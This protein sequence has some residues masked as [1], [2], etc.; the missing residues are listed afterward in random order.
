M[1]RK[2]MIFLYLSAVA[3]IVSGQ[4]ISSNV[5]NFCF[6]P[7]EV[8]ICRAHFP[9]FYFNTKTKSCDCFIYGGCLGND[10]RFP[11]LQECMQACH[12]RP[13]L[14]K[15]SAKCDKVLG[16][17]NPLANEQILN[18]IRQMSPLPPHHKSPFLAPPEQA[19]V[20]QDDPQQTPPQQSP[21]QQTG[22]F[23]DDPQQTPPQQPPPQQTPLTQD[24]PQQTPLIQH[25]PPQQIPPFQQPPPPQQSQ[26]YQP[27]QQSQLYQ[28]PQQTTRPQQIPQF[29]HRPQQIP[30]FQHRPQ[31]IHVC[32]QPQLTH[33]PVTQPQQ[34]QYYQR[35]QQTQHYQRPLGQL[36]PPALQT[37]THTNTDEDIVVSQIFQAMGITQGT[38]Y[39]GQPAYPIP[40]WMPINADN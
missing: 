25:D 1:A 10:N 15:N 5:P 29:Q 39:I 4:E 34:T 3:V 33:R 22:L 28:P 18:A 20:F 32:P 7:P 13:S 9:S 31:Q 27:P 12:V 21:P 35:P 37:W 14:Q 26:L 6:D 11:T 36:I 23:Q 17:D 8:G 24:D 38:L 19:P 16:S 30:Q 2:M 40:R